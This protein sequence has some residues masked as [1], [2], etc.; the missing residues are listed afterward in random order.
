MSNEEFL[1]SSNIAVNNRGCALE[2]ILYGWSGILNTN[3]N[4]SDN[5]LKNEEA[6]IP[7]SEKILFKL[8]RTLC[9]ALSC[10]QSFSP[11]EG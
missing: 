11:S 7:L 1:F 4:M 2:K 5:S 10:T 6:I 3:S 8:S 9:S